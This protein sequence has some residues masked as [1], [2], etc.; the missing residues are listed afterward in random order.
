MNAFTASLKQNGSGVGQPVDASYVFTLR[1]RLNRGDSFSAEEL[2]AIRNALRVAQENARLGSAG[3]VSLEG[4][5]NDTVWVNVL[6]RIVEQI[7]SS[8]TS[9]KSKAPGLGFSPQGASRTVNINL[10]GKTSSLS[11]S[12]EADAARLE[13]L[14]QEIAAAAGRST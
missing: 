4:R 13:A 2:P 11:M 5:Q 8:Q 6:S 7:E 14:L 3:S 12:S 10:N 9:I 1:E